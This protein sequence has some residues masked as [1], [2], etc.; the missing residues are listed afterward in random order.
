MLERNA[1]EAVEKICQLFS[2]LQHLETSQSSQHGLKRRLKQAE[3]R[4]KTLQGKTHL[5]DNALLTSQ[6][7]DQLTLGEILMLLS[8]HYASQSKSLRFMICA[9]VPLQSLGRTSM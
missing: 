8:H 6:S 7:S 5:T 3:K 4:Q 9:V 2:A 1:K